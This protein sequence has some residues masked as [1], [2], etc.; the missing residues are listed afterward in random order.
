MLLGNLF[1][2]QQLAVAK[3]DAL[4]DVLQAK[5]VLTPSDLE[6]IDAD[7]RAVLGETS[8]SDMVGD[9]CKVPR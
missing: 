9:S 8:I 3:L 7:I 6:A 4:V 5:G 2:M 1:I